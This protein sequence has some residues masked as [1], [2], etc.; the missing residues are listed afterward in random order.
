MFTWW[1]RLPFFMMPSGIT[2]PGIVVVVNE[3]STR[4]QLVARVSEN[5]TMAV[6]LQ[7]ISAEVIKKL[8]LAVAGGLYAPDAPQLAKRDVGSFR[9]HAARNMSFVNHSGRPFGLAVPKA[10]LPRSAAVSPLLAQTAMPVCTPPQRTG[11]TGPQS[12]G[13]LRALLPPL[14]IRDRHSSLLW[15]RAALRLWAR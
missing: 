5:A 8:L 14:P 10:S 9:P 2:K 4:T 11:S 3:A 13:G 1:S 6:F 12:P 7:S 15:Q